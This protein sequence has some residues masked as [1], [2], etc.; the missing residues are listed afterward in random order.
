MID[1]AA[2]FTIQEEAY[3]VAEKRIK[4]KNGV[5]TLEGHVK[6][7]GDPDGLLEALE[8]VLTR[9]SEFLYPDAISFLQKHEGA[10]FII[11]SFGSSVW[12]KRKIIDSGVEKL[13]NEV[14]ATE[15]D[16]EKIVTRW[17]DDEV[18]YFNDRGVEID[19]MQ[20]VHKDAKFVWVHRPGTPYF[21]EKC[22]AYTQEVQNLFEDFTHLL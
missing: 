21:G 7:L 12:Q 16:K 20:L 22:K 5:Y 18:V 10:D 11:L 17:E 3:R 15:Q 2:D 8:N 6:E 9:A 19:K 4:T 13:V 1:I 14:I